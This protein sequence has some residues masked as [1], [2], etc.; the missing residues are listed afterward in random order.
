M[1]FSKKHK[2][3]IATM[4]RCSRITGFCS[5]IEMD[6]TM[7]L[8]ISAGKNDVCVGFFATPET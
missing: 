7:K 6:L 1:N 2:N 4:A 5:F 3:I 8:R